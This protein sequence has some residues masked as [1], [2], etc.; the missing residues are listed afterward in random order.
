M[1]W[2]TPLVEMKINI[3]HDIL[4]NICQS[5]LT[6]STVTLFDAAIEFVVI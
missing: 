6:L 5:L 1:Y 3:P 2:Y 4:V